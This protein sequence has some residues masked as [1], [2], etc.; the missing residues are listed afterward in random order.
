MIRVQ[1]T[2]PPAVEPVLLDE[3]IIWGSVG[4]NDINNQGPDPDTRELVRS[5]IASE[6]TRIEEVCKRALVQTTYQVTFDAEDLTLDDGSLCT[7]IALPLRVRP[8]VS[9]TSVTWYDQN[10]V[11]STLVEGTDFYKTAGESPVIALLPNKTWPTSARDFQC[12]IVVCVAGHAAAIAPSV[13]TST[14]TL[15]VVSSTAVPAV[16]GVRFGCECLS[17]NPVYWTV[18][19]G[20]LANYSDEQIVRPATQVRVGGTDHYTA[21]PAPLAYYRVKIQSYTAGQPGVVDLRGINGVIPGLMLTAISECTKFFV[22]NRGSGL[23]VGT[24]G[25]KG[26]VPEYIDTILRRLSPFGTGTG[27]IG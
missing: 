22:E 27:V 5:Q 18:F 19:G 2:A 12:L 14:D 13:A 23:F 10:A 25:F 17:G 4:L 8:L 7:S 24:G 15:A 9:I 16:G 21:V 6:R 11:Q 1:Q 20:N 3:L 26:P